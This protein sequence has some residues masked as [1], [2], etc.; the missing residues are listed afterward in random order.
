LAA[1]TSLAAIINGGALLR[2]LIAQKAY[3]PGSDWASLI[4]RAVAAT[5]LMGLLLETGT[6]T[7]AEWLACDSA[8]R[9]GQLLGWILIGGLVYGGALALMGVRPRQLLAP[10]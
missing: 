3:Q 9:I 2:A 10:R 7:T 4:P 8:Q 1:A 6:A 5:L